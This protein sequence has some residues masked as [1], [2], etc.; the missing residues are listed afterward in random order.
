MPQRVTQ[1]M[2]NT[3]LLTN[4]NS[5]LKRLDNLQNQLATG[6]QINKPSD[7]PVGISFSMRYRSEISSND[8]YQKNAD[9]ASSWLDY[10]DTILNQAGDVIQRVRELAVQGANGTNPP[11]ALDAINSEMKQLYGQLVQIG[12]S[13]FNG[14]YVFNG[15]TTDVKPYTEATA[16]KDA[17]D[18]GDIQ[19]EVGVGSKLAVNITGDAV[20]GSAGSTTNAFAVVKNI[21]DNLSTGNY[22]GVS[23]SIGLLDS[24]TDIFLEKRA[25][26]GAKQNRI[27]L[28][29][30]RLKD[31]GVNITSLL[32]K[33]EDADMAK[34]I[35]QLKTDENVYEASLS[36]GSKIIRPSLLDFLK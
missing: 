10:S 31:T 5:N 23:D 15:Q 18:T 17:T 4:L 35:T 7:D 33:T 6:R 9:S 14:K 16:D 30:N 25:D 13:Q 29:T 34:V 27:D 36:T 24:R 22:Q 2:M 21:M 1:G 11:E 28:T 3:Q 32:S 19:F 12:N 20:F 26:I 8:Q